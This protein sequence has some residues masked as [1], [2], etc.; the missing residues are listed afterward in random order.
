MRVLDVGSGTGSVAFLAA[1]L[2]GSSGQ[3]I[4]TDL[5]P[6]AV[7]TASKAATA[8]ALRHVSF[9]EGNPAE[10]TFERPF[11]AIVGRYVLWCQGDLGAMLRAL[12]KHLWPAG[13]IAFH[14]PDWSF[15]RSEPAIAMYDRW[16]RGSLKRVTAPAPAV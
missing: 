7:A 10:M 14:E 15:A 2:V 1:E 8:K 11:D 16:C 4:G 12:A 6:V 3:V 5:A 13:V 9:R